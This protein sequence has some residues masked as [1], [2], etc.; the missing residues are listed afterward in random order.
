MLD[1]TDKIEANDCNLVVYTAVGT[2]Q[3]RANRC[4]RLYFLWCIHNKQRRLWIITNALGPFANER[5]YDVTDSRQRMPPRITLLAQLRSQGELV[6]ETVR[7]PN[8]PRLGVRSHRK[9]SCGGDTATPGSRLPPLY[10]AAQSKR[11]R[12]KRW[13]G[14]P[15]AGAARGWGPPRADRSASGARGRA[16]GVCRDVCTDAMRAWASS[17]ILPVHGSWRLR[18]RWNGILRSSHLGEQMSRKGA[19]SAVSYVVTSDLTSLLMVC[20]LG[21]R[22]NGV[23]LMF[24]E[25]SS[26]H[27]IFG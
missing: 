11:L 9:K 16:R 14:P 21:R 23:I 5:A 3:R 26:S 17:S 6:C 24:S 8:P 4:T 15:P 19:V 13:I 20:L 27:L 25:M 22:W 12:G 10:A 18:T 1:A 7:C 2:N